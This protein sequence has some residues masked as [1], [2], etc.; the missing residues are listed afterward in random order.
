MLALTACHHDEPPTPAEQHYRRTV[1]VYMAMQNS[2]GSSGYHRNDS[3]EIANAMGFIPEGDRLLLFIDDKD[4]PR[5][6]E[7][8]KDLTNTDKKT[9]QPYGPRLLKKWKEDVS[10]ASASTLTEV[11][12]YAR[13]NFPSDSYGL[14]MG[15]HATGWL[16]TEHATPGK[17]QHKV[18]KRTWGIDVGPDG[19][20]SSDKGVA[21]SVPDQIEMTDLAAA[22]TKSGIQLDYLLFDACLMQCAEVAYT[23]RKVTPYLIASP[24]SIA[25]EGA[26][27]TDLVH[28]G[29]FSADPIDVARAYADYYQGKGSIPYRDD[30]GTVIS[31][32]RTAG[33]EQLASTVRDILNEILPNTDATA[34]FNI[35][36]TRNMTPALNYH[37][38]SSSFYYRPHY[39]DLLSAIK[40]LGAN[41]EL[42]SRLYRVL[43][44]VVAYK[45]AND[46]FWIGP[47]V[48][49]YKTMPTN[50]ADWCG[51]SMFVPQ[52]IYSDNAERCIFGDLNE[53][54]KATEW[55]RVIYGL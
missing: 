17:S 13:E 9:G 37:P 6:Y 47:G 36:K 48:R 22:I 54:Y 51:V 11:L 12:Q 3:V 33:M 23:L 46:M 41:D 43:D 7:L 42:T 2:L 24:I 38:Y 45:A 5:I 19:W 55:Y 30:Y 1:L 26:Y 27:Y 25:A 4:M 31:C 21:G 34:K 44:E 40:T 29:L 32:I 18:A 8:S 14:V 20:M 53:D 16:P 39:Y 15:S 10:T 35:L 52:Q 49:A 50:E 28:F